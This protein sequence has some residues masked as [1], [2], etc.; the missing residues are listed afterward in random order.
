MTCLVIVGS[1]WAPGSTTTR[2]FY[3]SNGVMTDLGTLGGAS[4]DARGLNDDGDVV[5]TAQNAAGQPRA[6]LYRSGVMTDLNTLVPPGTGWVLESA[7]AISNGDQ[8]VGYGTF[9]G[10]RRAFLLTPPTDLVLASAAR[11]VSMTAT[12]RVTASKWERQSSGRRRPSRPFDSS[13]VS[14]RRRIRT[15]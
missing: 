5:G 14:V 10:K 2:A 12:C 11:S 8:I 1:L 3:Y 4:S 13:R 7:A 6:F 15:R 9:N